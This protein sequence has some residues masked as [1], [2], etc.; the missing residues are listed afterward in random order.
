MRVAWAKRNY[1][2]RSQLIDDTLW[3]LDPRRNLRLSGGQSTTEYRVQGVRCTRNEDLRSDFEV[4]DICF[5][6]NHNQVKATA[7]VKSLLP[8]GKSQGYSHARNGDSHIWLS[9]HGI[10]GKGLQASHLYSM[11]LFSIISLHILRF[12]Y[13]CNI[14]LQGINSIF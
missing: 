10:F 13:R 8:L 6:N 1:K 2:S 11:S 14:F 3:P 4:T 5:A 12:V 7:E 9:G